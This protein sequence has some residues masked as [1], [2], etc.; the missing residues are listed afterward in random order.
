LGSS[1]GTRLGGRKLE[2]ARL[3]PVAP[4]TLIEMGLVTMMVHGGDLLESEDGGATPASEADANEPTR[5]RL[6]RLVDLVARSRL[7]VILSGETGVGKEVMAEEI[8]RRSPR[9]GAPLV[10]I[11]CAAF[12]EALL[13]GELFGYERG[14]FTGAAQAKPG[15]IETADQG[16]LLLDEVAEMPLPV[17]AKLLRVLEGREVQRLGALTP[18]KVD[19]RFISAS[20]VD[21]EAAAKSGK[22]RM[23]LFFRLNGITVIIP[24]LRD[25]RG[26]IPA[27]V[28][29]FVMSA[30]Q[31]ARTAVVA[32]TPAAL[33]RMVQH[34][35]PGNIRELRNVI[36]RA[37]VLAA[38]GDVDV[39]H[40][41]GVG[42]ASVDAAVRESGAGLG[43]RLAETERQ[44]ILEA[45]AQTS[46]NQKKAAELLGIS[47]RTLINRLDQYGLP[48]PRKGEDPGRR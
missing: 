32:V 16:S 29:Q 41:P 1:N 2:R 5:E 23:D 38:G 30:C 22:F 37:L 10:K 15:L 19:V 45:L 31:E 4:G 25:R 13:E 7:S 24:P 47:R 33:D 8:H 28:R 21:L 6:E 11:N 9:A 40:L 26:E 20:H 27:L 39:A 14:A 3:E 34:D 36:D 17:Q 46:G 43:D 48:R 12:P 35:W 42:A 44:H 18:R